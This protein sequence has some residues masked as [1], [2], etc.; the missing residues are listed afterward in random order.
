[1]TDLPDSLARVSR[2]ALESSRTAYARYLHLLDAQRAA[3][4]AGDDTMLSALAAEATAVLERLDHGHRLP[5]EL[6]EC[7][8]HATGPRAREVRGLMAALRLEAETASASVQEF[9]GQLEARRRSLL[10]A[11]AELSGGGSP[12]RPPRPAPAALDTTG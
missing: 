8:H 10:G 12:F 2:Q 1:M 6:G 7:L 11:L 3:L 4:R 9:T 5:P